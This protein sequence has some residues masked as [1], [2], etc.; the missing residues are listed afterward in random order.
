[1]KKW[2]VGTLSMGISLVLLG[3]VLFISQWKGLQA[4]DTFIT[5][6]PV[7]FILLGLEIV[8]YLSFSKKENSILSYDIMSLFFVGVLC[9]G[10]LGF[11]ML[12]S[13]GVLGEVRAM[14][15]AVDET[16][17][18]PEVKEAVAE[19]V[20]KVVVQSQDQ[21]VKV[22]KSQERAVHVFGTYRSR[23]KQG[24]Q[25]GSLEKEQFVAVRTVGDTMYV[26]VKRLPEKRGLDSF[27][28]RMTATVVLPQDVQVEVRGWNNEI[29]Q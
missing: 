17:D 28:P 4:F 20:K 5:W 26:Q 1:M 29:V 25:A 19:G 27:Y 13:V 22:D 23:T 10:C 11:T 24:E 16:K 2:R 8:L 18:L 15:G 12:T 7:I 14:L 3:V 9:I 21:T 6:W